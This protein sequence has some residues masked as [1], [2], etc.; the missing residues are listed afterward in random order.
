M[1]LAAQ[2]HVHPALHHRMFERGPSKRSSATLIFGL[3]KGLGHQIDF[4]YFDKK[5][6]DLSRRGWFLQLLGAYIKVKVFLPV[7]AH[8]FRHRPW[9]S[10]S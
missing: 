4:K 6:A 3:L 10:I 5:L 8:F 9:L 2:G 1:L 7:N